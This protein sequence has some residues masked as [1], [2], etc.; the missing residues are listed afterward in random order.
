LC[1]SW[2]VAPGRS[3]QPICMPELGEPFLN[4]PHA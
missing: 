1:F 2:A 4:R 3:I